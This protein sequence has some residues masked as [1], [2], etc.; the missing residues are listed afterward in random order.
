MRSPTFEKYM[1]P[2]ILSTMIF[3][4]T[5]L[6]SAAEKYFP[7]N[8]V[9]DF[10]EQRYSKHLS[11]MQEPVLPHTNIPE[12]FFALRLLYLPTWGPPVAVRYESQDGK[13]FRRS[14]MLTGQGGYEPGKI[15]KQTKEGVSQE[16]VD[17]IIESLKSAMVWQMEEDDGVIGLDGSQL[18]IETIWNSEYQ[19]R[20]RWTPEHDTKARGLQGLVQIYTNEFQSSGFWDKQKE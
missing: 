17:S 16:D 19:V 4:V 3:A 13:H 9:S 1:R 10:E 5:A 12:R 14:V 18:I 11:A 20:T 6:C 15:K 8:S 2:L 7:D